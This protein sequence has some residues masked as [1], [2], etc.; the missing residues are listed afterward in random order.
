MP[1]ED[2]IQNTVQSIFEREGLYPTGRVSSV[3]DIGCGL[4]LKSQYIDANVRVGVDIYRP[5]LEKIDA[6]VPYAVVNADALD[7]EKLFLPKSFD[8][9]LILDLVEHLEKETSVRL[10]Q[11]AEE[12]ARVAVIIETPLG[13]IPQNIDIWGWGGHE[14]QTH[15]SGWEVEDFT[16]RGY[17]VVVRDYTMS[18]VQR[19]TDVEVDPHIKMIDAICLMDGNKSKRSA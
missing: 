14:Y 9:V 6:Q 18:D 10:I 15:R 13:Y 16:S 4:S 1:K 5:Y 8:L 19:H 7:I 11:M 3:L 17:Q 12:I 2:W